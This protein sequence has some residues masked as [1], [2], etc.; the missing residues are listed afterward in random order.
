MPICWEQN[1]GGLQEKDFDMEMED[2]DYVTQKPQMW[3]MMKNNG[4]KILR[5]TNCWMINVEARNW[6]LIMKWI[7][8][9]Q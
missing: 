1:G 2:E 3:G 7:M 5:S 9:Y 8:K 6:C 4:W